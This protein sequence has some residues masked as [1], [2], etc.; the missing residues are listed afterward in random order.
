VKQTF[1]VDFYPFV[2]G[3]TNDFSAFSSMFAWRKRFVEEYR[4][5]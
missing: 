4:R 5:T 3:V 2:M 1:E